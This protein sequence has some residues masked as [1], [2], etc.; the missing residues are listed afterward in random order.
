MYCAVHTEENKVKAIVIENKDGRQA[1]A[2]DFFIDAS[3]DGDIARDLKI[4]CYKNIHR[5]P[6]TPCFKINGDISGISI[7]KLVQE[8]GKEFG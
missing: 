8:H 5:Q 3:G 4:P 7:S 1:I 2:A 6:P